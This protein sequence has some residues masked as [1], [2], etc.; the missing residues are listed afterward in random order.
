MYHLTGSIETY[1]PAC[2]TVTRHSVLTGP[3]TGEVF[4]CEH[5]T[6]VGNGK[7]CGNTQQQKHAAYTSDQAHGQPATKKPTDANIVRHLLN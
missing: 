4:R 7:P 3:Q 2:E 5:I 6:A 1:C